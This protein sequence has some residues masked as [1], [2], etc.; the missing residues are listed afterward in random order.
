[1]ILL[2][3]AI[4][5]QA[6]GEAADAP[7]TWTPEQI[8]WQSFP[9]KPDKTLAYKTVTGKDGAP[10]KLKLQ[11]FL[12]EGWQASDKRPAAVLFHGG[13]WYGGGPDHYYPQSRYLALRGMVA[14]SVEYRTINRFGTTP[15]ECVKDGK[16]AMRWVK[17]HA[18]ELGIDPEQIVAGGGS[19]GGHIAAA[20]ALVRAFDEAGDDMSVSCIP[21]ALLLFN[22]VFDNGPEGFAHDLVK[23]YWKGIS[24]IDHIDAKTPPAFVVLGTE[25]VHVPI[26]TAKRFERLMNE[27]GRRCDLHLY[28]G[29]KH[30]WYNL[31]VSRDAMAEA[32]IRMDHFLM[33]LDYLHGEPVLEL[34]V[35]S[36]SEATKASE[37]PLRIMCLGD[38]ITVG[39]TDNPVWK[40]P[41]KFGYR[42]RLYQL[43]KEAGYTFNFVGDSPQPWD[44][45]SGD[46]S[47]G[48]TYKPEFDLRDLGQ[49]YHQGGRG[50]PIAALKGWVSKDDPDVVLLMIGINGISTQSPD[51]IRSLVQTIVT[52]KPDAHLIVAQITPY[53]STQTAKNKFLYNYNVYIRDT[54]VPEFAA[55]GHNVSTVDMYSLF[56]TD[57]HDYES[58]VAPGKH[59]NNYNHPFNG[60]YDRMADRWFAAIEVL[61]LEKGN[62]AATPAAQAAPSPTAKPQDT[63][64]PLENG[65]IPKTFDALWQGFDPQKEPLD[66]EVLKEWEEDGVVMKVLRYRVAIFNGKKGMMAAVYGYPK[67]AKNLPGLIHIHG[68]GQMA[69]AVHVLTNA[70]RGYATISLA[71]A[72]RIIAPEYTV[73]N[74]NVKAFKSGNTSDPNYIV[75]TDW[76]GVDA[77]TPSEQ[78][79]DPVNSP[80]NTLWFYAGMGCR[81]ALTFLER[82]KEVD[83]NRLGVYGHSMGGKLTVITAGS[84]TRVKAAAP[85][86]GGISDIRKVRNIPGYTTTIDDDVYLKRITCPI[87]FQSPTNDFHA[88]ADDLTLAAN[89]VKSTE[90]RITSAA[91][92]NHNDLEENTVLQPLWFDQSLK[93]TFASAKTPQAELILKTESAIPRFEVKPD[94]PDK[95][96]ELTV[97]YTEEGIPGG[98]EKYHDFPTR[99]WKHAPA[100]RHGD[101]WV[102]EIPT[103][104]TDKHLWV[105]ANARYPIGKPVSAAGYGCDRYTAND[106]VLSSL[107]SMVTP[108]QK[109]AAGV[110]ATQKHSL[111][112]EDFS[113]D[114]AKRWFHSRGEHPDYWAVNTFKALRPMHM[115]PA[116]AK[117]V[118]EARSEKDNRLV[119]SAFSGWAAGEH[120]KKSATS[121]IKGGD[122]WQAISLLPSDFRDKQNKPLTGWPEMKKLQLAGPKPRPEL[123][124][125][126]WKEVP[127]RELMA[128]RNMKLDQAQPVDGRTY[129]DSKY[130]DLFTSGY[131]VVMNTSCLGHPLAMGDKTYERGIGTHAPSRGV[132]FL[133]GLYKRFH[134]EV[135]I[136]KHQPG[137]LRLRVRLDKREV[138]YSGLM[139]QNAAPKTIDLDVSGAFELELLVDNAGDN[140]N[141]DHGNWCN[142][143]LTQ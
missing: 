140:S 11:I 71:W 106:Y 46:P 10:V 75:T 45:I 79:I 38:S 86:C 20:M 80:R 55:K 65:E 67:G 47:H 142:A 130:A 118:I 131:K 44:A 22:P 133:K 61:G 13:G 117:L 89:H 104:S 98:R 29:K 37:E 85:S 64:P 9:L 23:A 41:F 30:G 100:K 33:S 7:K 82:Q 122:Q 21:K 141:G 127:V 27:N 70:K 135:G 132:F 69:H 108:Q 128:S 19:A 58:A 94:Q 52:D 72:G 31:W 59:S 36:K 81:R 91:H 129:L 51:R 112:I 17:A 57:I 24:P 125:L 116:A 137:S 54:L 87:V 111:I 101:T 105:Y 96:T 83:G 28:E 92:I 2:A 90:W 3:T 49:D 107:M 6:I 12:P 103:F 76:V 73:N 15:K 1:V 40:V 136:Q 77:P 34:N 50:S 32:L 26:E 123:R 121:T 143:Y 63:L 88:A 39:Y 78:T 66:V 99:Y 138:Y 139:T 120:T 16:S 124:N 113:E 114:W 42:S 95:M 93:H 14:I 84:D 48:G 126:H 18:A 60:D 119:I 68:G 134:A 62:L 53:V 102:A 43:L 115:P 4:A 74:D 5:L 109:T 110:K 8:G 56:L 97:Y 25:D 35:E